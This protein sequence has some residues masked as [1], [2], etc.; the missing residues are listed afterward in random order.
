MKITCISLLGVLFMEPR[1]LLVHSIQTT[2]RDVIARSRLTTGLAAK[3]RGQC[4][5]TGSLGF[6]RVGRGA[7]IFLKRRQCGAREVSAASK[8]DVAEPTS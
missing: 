4:G 7:V 1:G 6:G 8:E 5:W 3:L 2:F